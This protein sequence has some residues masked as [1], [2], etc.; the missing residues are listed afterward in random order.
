MEALVL[1]GV[2]PLRVGFS[3]KTKDSIEAHTLDAKLA[4]HPL[5]SRI[6]S[7]CQEL[8]KLDKKIQDIQRKLTPFDKMNPNSS[9]IVTRL[10]THCISNLFY[11][12]T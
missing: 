5:K 3:G 12:C 10:S 9:K 6:D 8:D 1:A 4:A 7:V 11:H 2:N